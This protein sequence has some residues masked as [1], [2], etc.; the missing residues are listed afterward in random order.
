YATNVTYDGVGRLTGW[1]L[2]NGVVESLGYDGERMQLTSQ[3][4]TKGVTSLMNLNYNYQASAGQ[5]GAGTTA[6]NAGQLMSISGTIG[7]L[8]ESAA[9]TYD[10]VERLA[11]SN[12]TSNLAMA[13]RRFAYDRWGNRTGVWNA[14]SGGSQIQSI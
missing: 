2:G 5:M 14:V 13:A 6:G 7:G 10:N 9:Y 12:Q 3:T 1:T 8:T 11:T 4:A